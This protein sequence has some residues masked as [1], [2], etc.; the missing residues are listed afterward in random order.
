MLNIHPYL[1]HFPIAL[2]PLAFI[3]D[4]LSLSRRATFLAKP[5]W[6]IQCV[7][8]GMLILT[9]VSGLVARSLAVVPPG[10]IES[11]DMHQQLAFVSAGLL[12][13][14]FFWKLASRGETPQRAKLLYSIVQAVAVCV[15]LATS[16]QGGELVY[17]FGVGIGPR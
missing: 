6:V 17:T 11:F 2:F 1:V 12:L 10:A 8:T 3:F 13:G 14:L 7:G 9:V 16:W 4:I 5:G 15:L